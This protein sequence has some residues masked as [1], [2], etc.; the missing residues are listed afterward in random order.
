MNL[1]VCRK[2]EV[3]DIPEKKVRLQIANSVEPFWWAVIGAVPGAPGTIINARYL[4][5]SSALA[6]WHCCQCI[7][8]APCWR[9]SP[10]TVRCCG[11]SGRPTPHKPSCPQF[12]LWALSLL[13]VHTQVCLLRSVTSSKLCPGTSMPPFC[14][15]GRAPAGQPFGRKDHTAPSVEW[16]AFWNQSL[17]GLC[18][19]SFISTV[20]EEELLKNSRAHCNFEGRALWIRNPILHLVYINVVEGT[21]GRNVHH[22]SQKNLQFLLCWLCGSQLRN[23]HHFVPALLFDRSVSLGGQ[24][25]VTHIHSS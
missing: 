9:L 10:R 5:S 8:G 19:H 3:L 18:S 1:F 22:C 21:V 12:L 6:L 13:A 4:H 17:Q 7:L 14:V 16:P 2:L 24:L 20:L 25:L 23:T 11:W 15:R